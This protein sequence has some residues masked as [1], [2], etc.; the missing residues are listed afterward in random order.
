MD[1]PLPKKQMDLCPGRRILMGAA[2]IIMRLYLVQAHRFQA[3]S[4][5]CQ[6]LFVALGSPTGSIHLHKPVLA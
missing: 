2:D 6:S 5:H 4:A 3:W 1:F